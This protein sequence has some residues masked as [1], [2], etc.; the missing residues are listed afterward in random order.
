MLVVGGGHLRTN[1]G[2]L[3]SMKQIRIHFYKTSLGKEPVRDWL[4]GLS[5]DDKKLI[6]AEMK[7]VEFGWPIGMPVVRKIE[8]D[9]WEVRIHIT[10]GIARVLFT[11][12]DDQMILLHGFVKKSQK[13]PANELKTTRERLKD[14]HHE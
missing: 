13:M 3:Y 1:F 14:L 4:L 7:T 5:I 9:L 6:G 10:D 2:T 11:V 12:I 8:R